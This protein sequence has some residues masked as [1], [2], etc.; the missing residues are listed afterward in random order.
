M[1]IFAV[2]IMA[3]IFLGWVFYIAFIKKTLKQNKI[4][5]LLGFFF[6]AVWGIIWI[7][8]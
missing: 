1:R 6:F 8:L 2:P 7:A 4:L 5:V 3:I